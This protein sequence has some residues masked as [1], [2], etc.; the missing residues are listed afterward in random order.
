[1]FPWI[2]RNALVMAK[3]LD[4]E[5]KECTYHY[6]IYIYIYNNYEICP[7]SLPN[8]VKWHVKIHCFPR[9]YIIQMTRCQGCA[10][11]HQ[12]HHGQRQL[13]R[14]GDL[15]SATHNRFRTPKIVICPPCT[16]FVYG[17]LDVRFFHAWLPLVVPFVLN[18]NERYSE[19]FFDPYRCCPSPI[20][21][22]YVCFC[23]FALTFLQ[24]MFFIQ[25]RHWIQRQSGPIQST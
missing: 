12:R 19:H 25:K 8:S 2:S 7:I 15:T 9:L 11:H 18:Y 23:S 3:L 22:C 4:L 5:I 10:N 24:R 13:C 1:M 20:V 6:N 21:C 16:H 14:V 17:C